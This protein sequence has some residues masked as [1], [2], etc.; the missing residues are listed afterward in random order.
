MVYGGCG[1]YTVELNQTLLRCDENKSEAVQ[2]QGVYEVELSDLKRHEEAHIE[3]LNRADRHMQTCM[4][5]LDMRATDKYHKN[6]LIR[7]LQEANSSALQQLSESSTRFHDMTPHI[8][9]YTYEKGLELPGPKLQ[10]KTS[11]SSCSTRSSEYYTDMK[12]AVASV[13]LEFSAAPIAG[14]KSSAKKSPKQKTKG[15]R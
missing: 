6:I 9:R 3:K 5:N 4:K 11:S 2:L 12:P 10:F 14:P 1:G 15:K 8:T 7:Q 13:L